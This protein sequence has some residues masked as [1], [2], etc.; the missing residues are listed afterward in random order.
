MTTMNPLALDPLSPIEDT[1]W[2]TGPLALDPLSPE[3][4][5]GASL[6]LALTAPGRWSAD[7][8]RTSDLTRHSP[9]RDHAH[10]G[11]KVTT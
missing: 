4:T 10:A 1:H 2:A 3:H 9:I 7:A 8:A 5:A 6:A 11:G